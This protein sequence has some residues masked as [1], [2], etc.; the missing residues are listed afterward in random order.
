MF[1]H[2]NPRDILSTYLMTLKCV[3]N[4]NPQCILYN[5]VIDFEQNHD[6]RL[7]QLV[8]GTQL[9][10]YIYFNG[11]LLLLMA[12]TTSDQITNGVAK[13]LLKAYNCPVWKNDNK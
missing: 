12:L 11:R 13:G 8:T 9:I 2:P 3:S 6:A 5:P 1:A 7:F 4:L 10:D